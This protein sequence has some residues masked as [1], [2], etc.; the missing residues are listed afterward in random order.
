MVRTFQDAC[1]LWSTCSEVG[2]VKSAHLSAGVLS[3]LVTKRDLA[4]KKTRTALR[5]CSR[6]S[7][8]EF[9]APS[10]PVDMTDAALFSVSPSGKLAA[11]VRASEDADGRKVCGAV[12]ARPCG[13][14]LHGHVSHRYM[15]HVSHGDESDAR[16]LRARR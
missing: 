2:A 4:A 10:F 13:P 9:I 11:V 6:D 15:R 14:S 16:V 3:V 12:A 5:T 8:G 1:R 7:V